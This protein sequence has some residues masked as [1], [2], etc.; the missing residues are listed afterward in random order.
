MAPNFEQFQTRITNRI[1][2]TIETV[3][4]KGR[5]GR[6]S[7]S[8]HNDKTMRISAPI[9]RIAC[10]PE[11]QRGTKIDQHQRGVSLEKRQIFYAAPIVLLSECEAAFVQQQKNCLS[12]M[13]NHILH[14]IFS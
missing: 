14:D 3:P 10:S 7:L 8:Y 5:K 4:E 11:Q 13:D 2:L 1:K 12:P 9:S 6:K